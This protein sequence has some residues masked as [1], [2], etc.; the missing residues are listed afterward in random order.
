MHEFVSNVTK[1]GLTPPSCV[2]QPRLRGNCC[3]VLLPF[4]S[5]Y[6]ILQ[7]GSSGESASAARLNLKSYATWQPR[8]VRPGECHLAVM[9]E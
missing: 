6:S 1:S 9:I 5:N 4:H 7:T 2:C 8:C 3:I